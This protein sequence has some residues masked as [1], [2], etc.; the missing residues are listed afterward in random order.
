MDD[1]RPAGADDPAGELRAWAERF[2]AALRRLPR[3]ERADWIAGGSP[4]ADWLL[5]LGLFDESEEERL[6]AVRRILDRA[7]P[8]IDRVRWLAY[9]AEFVA[10]LDALS[11]SVRKL[12]EARAFEGE[13]TRAVGEYT[14]A[15]MRDDPALDERALRRLRAALD[16]RVS[17]DLLGPAWRRDREGRHPAVDL[18]AAEKDA[19]VSSLERAIMMTLVYDGARLTSGEREVLELDAEG[20]STAE[21]ADSLDTSKAA[22]RRRRSDARRKLREA[23]VAS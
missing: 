20:Y 5:A 6:A 14:P 19:E 15:D 1:E 17:E 16:R 13:A 7:G 21:I 22:V 9:E 3:F 18:A 8:T 2:R 10:A 12:A 11:T 4:A 23:G